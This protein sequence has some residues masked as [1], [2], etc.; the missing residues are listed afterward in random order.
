MF[1]MKKEEKTPAIPKKAP[2]QKKSPPQN[3]V[4]SKKIMTEASPECSF[5]INNG[6]IVKD[7]VEL[8]DVLNSISDEMYDY[9]TKRDGNDFSKWVEEVLKDI[10]CAQKLKKARN[11]QE[12]IIIIEKYI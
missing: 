2:I 7:L 10:E 5:W 4:A 6:P 8:R 12:A 9:H 1:F 11:R 3:K